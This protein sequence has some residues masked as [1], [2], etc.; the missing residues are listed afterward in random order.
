MA[1]GIEWR[2]SLQSRPSYAVLNEPFLG[3]NTINE[4]KRS[5]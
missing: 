4:T 2:D 5:R 3:E 1:A